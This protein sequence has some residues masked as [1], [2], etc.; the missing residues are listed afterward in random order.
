LAD[1]DTE[2]KAKAISVAAA[3]QRKQPA[4]D[5]EWTKMGDNDGGDD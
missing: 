1:G 5:D 2:A 4:A 3:R